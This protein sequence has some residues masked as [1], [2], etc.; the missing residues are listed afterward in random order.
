[1]WVDVVRASGHAVESRIP[2]S[3]G[4]QISLEGALARVVHEKGDLALLFE[5]P[6][7]LDWQVE[8]APFFP[9]FHQVVERSVL[10][11]RGRTPVELRTRLRLQD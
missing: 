6:E 3:P 7:S 9:G 11:G 8:S 4:W 1:M 5:L 10:V 2:L